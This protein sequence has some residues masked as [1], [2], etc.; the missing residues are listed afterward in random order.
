MDFNP[1]PKPKPKNGPGGFGGPEG[2][3]LAGSWLAAV[4]C[5]PSRLVLYDAGGHSGIGWAVQNYGWLPEFAFDHLGRRPL[6]EGPPVDL[7]QLRD[8]VDRLR[9]YDAIRPAVPRKA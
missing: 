7:E 5:P 6:A 9:A 4:D 8:A 2:A 3:L 1:E